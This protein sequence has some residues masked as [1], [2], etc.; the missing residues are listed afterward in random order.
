MIYCYRSI[1]NK[2]FVDSVVLRELLSLSRGKFYRL[3]KSNNLP[4]T[5]IN[6]KHIYNIDDV[7]EILKILKN[8]FN[9]DEL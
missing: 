2:E 1:D 6:N 8:N 7:Y 9:N 4:F 5:K 3:K